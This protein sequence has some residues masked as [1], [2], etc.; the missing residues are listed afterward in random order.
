MAML[1]DVLAASHPPHWIRCPRQ[2]DQLKVVTKIVQH[3]VICR[4]VSKYQREN[5]KKKGF[6]DWSLIHWFWTIIG[7]SLLRQSH[8]HALIT[9]KREKYLK[10]VT[11]K[12]KRRKYQVLD[13]LVWNI[14][15]I[16]LQ[17]IARNVT[18]NPRIRMPKQFL[19]FFSFSHQD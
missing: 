12:N 5:W 13:Y 4:L 9:R 6:S 3:F 14:M 2:S 15:E 8:T 11:Y 19:D 7:T 16:Y 10:G 1:M 17:K 18:H